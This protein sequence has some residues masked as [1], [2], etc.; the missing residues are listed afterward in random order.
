MM[1]KRS[2]IVSMTVLAACCMAS[3]EVFVGPRAPERG[4]GIVQNPQFESGGMSYADNWRPLPGAC[5]M[6][7]KQRESG[8][9]SL[10]M[11][12]R[13]DGDGGVIQTVNLPSRRRLSLRILA[14][15]HADS[16]CAV[17]ATLTRATDGEV[18]AEVVVD[19]IE[20]GVLA[21]GFET[22]PGGPAELM[23]RVVGED[24]GRALV[25]RV[26]IAE[27]V[28]ARYARRPDYSGPDLLLARGEGLRVDADFR[29]SLL[30][31]AARM[32]QEAIEDITGAPTTSIGATV[33]VSVGQPQVTDWPER[34]SYHLTVSETGV[35]ISAPAEQG[36]VWAMMTLIDLIRAEPG[37]GARILG[38]DVQDRSALPWRIAS[39]PDFSDPANTARTLARLKL[40]MAVV[41]YEDKRSSAL[42]NELRSLGIEPVL[43]IE[44]T[45][46]DDVSGSMQDA[47]TRLR[48]RYLLLRPYDVW[49]EDGLTA[50]DWDRPAL[51][52]VID[53]ARNRRDQVTVMMGAGGSQPEAWPKKIVPVI[54]ASDGNAERLDRWICAGLPCVLHDSGAAV[55]LALKQ[56][57]AGDRCMGVVLEIEDLHSP[58][59]QS[60]AD[61]A[62]RG[63]PDE[64]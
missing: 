42:V 22:G 50:H 39:V 20:R 55:P 9:H 36:A 54:G 10:F 62:W 19:G 58:V 26:T 11:E 64:G 47:V 25:D 38:V 60:L 32:L 33:M 61:L 23:V 59:T 15:C 48:A 24:G 52:E 30:P 46:A 37:G 1:P 57:A 5:R 63:L 16:D 21:E 2:L 44:T 53:F 45:E 40:N 43:N 51:R 3:A 27:P 6:H 49:A 34:E 35:T 14:T 13:E 4:L 12:L 28:P 29:P 56:S 8:E 41:Q 7:R 17:V 31:Q 18:L